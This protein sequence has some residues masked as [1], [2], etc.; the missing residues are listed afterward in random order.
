MVHLDCITAETPQGTTDVEIKRGPGEVGNV[1][2]V[3]RS[4]REVLLEIPQRELVAAVNALTSGA[5]VA[6]GED[7][8]AMFDSYDPD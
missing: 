5:T 4:D 1:L 2:F 8:R 7:I 6:V 3:R